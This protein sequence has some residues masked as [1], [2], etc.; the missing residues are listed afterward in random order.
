MTPN[1]SVL[2]IVI[3]D[4]GRGLG[5]ALEEGWLARAGTLRLPSVEMRRGTLV[6]NE[7]V[8]ESRFRARVGRPPLESEMGCAAAHLSA[9]EALLQSRSQWALVLEDD[10]LVADCDSLGELV[11]KIIEMT[12]STGHVISLYSEGPLFASSS[13]EFE[14][15]LPLTRLRLA[16][17]GAVAYLV[18]RVA[19]RKLTAAQSPL[20]NVSDWPLNAR[21]LE[22][23]YVPNSL[24]DH[25]TGGT[26]STVAVDVDRSKLIPAHVRILMWTGLWF[27]V[28]RR[29]FGRFSNYREQILRP[30]YVRKL[31]IQGWY[32]RGNRWRRGHG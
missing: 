27:L 17:Q 3:G 30:R 4:P 22:F 14:T 20:S 15:R 2:P 21:D 26:A 6:W 8:D 18:D 10:A 29:H 25:A 13:A 1:E 28:H 19:A 24:I 16:P 7:R 12:K 5:P 11:A 9:Y 32:Y 23:Y 31:W